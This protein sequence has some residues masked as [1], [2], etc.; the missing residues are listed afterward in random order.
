MTSQDPRKKTKQ[1]HCSADIETC[2][3]YICIDVLCHI[4]SW[5]FQILMRCI[6][7]YTSVF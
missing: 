4:V 7:M 3:Y 1:H 5:Y 6:T 2:T